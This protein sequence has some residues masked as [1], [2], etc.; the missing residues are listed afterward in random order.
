M[1]SSRSQASGWYLCVQAVEAGPSRIS[2]QYPC[3]CPL[4]TWVFSVEFSNAPSLYGR[5]ISSRHSPYSHRFPHW[6]RGFRKLTFVC[7]FSGGLI[8]GKTERGALISCFLLC[9]VTLLWYFTIFLLRA[10]KDQTDLSLQHFS[11]CPSCLSCG[12][13]H[14]T[15]LRVFSFLYKWQNKKLTLLFSLFKNWHPA[16]KLDSDLNSD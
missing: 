14:T 4:L 3:L 12:T 9:T 15:W 6:P 1:V 16:S 5:F 7:L 11:H 13:K 2:F 10:R 8:W